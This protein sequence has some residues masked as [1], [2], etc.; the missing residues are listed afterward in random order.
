M[1]D[2]KII[3]TSSPFTG[4]PSLVPNTNDAEIIFSDIDQFVGHLL[5]FTPKYKM[6]VVQTIKSST[7]LI[8]DHDSI[9][10]KYGGTKFYVILDRNLRE[11]LIDFKE[12]L[13]QILIT[14]FREKEM[15]GINL[16]STSN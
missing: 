16:C 5:N 10:K 14:A 1:F 9:A 4:L 13:I 11:G 12:K 2:H 15:E 8:F 3:L 6:K 7:I